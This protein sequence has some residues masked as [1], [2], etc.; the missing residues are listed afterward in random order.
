ME[1][2][3]IGRSYSHRIR[4]LKTLPVSKGPYG[5]I[6]HPAYLGTLLAHAGLVTV[7]L[8]PYSLGALLL[9]LAAVL[10][11]TCVE[12]TWLL[13]FPEYKEYTK[14]VHWKLVPGIF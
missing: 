5:I 7:F 12:D 4:P 9:W 3:K 6:R 8:N 11:R 14:Q 2:A 10:I 1:I 13:K